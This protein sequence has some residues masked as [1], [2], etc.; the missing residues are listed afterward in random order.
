MKHNQL[1]IIGLL[2]TTIIFSC[3]NDSEEKTTITTSEVTPKKEVK[4]RVLTPEQSDKVN[5]LWSKVSVNVDT[6]SFIRFMTSA[7]IA[8]TLLS[9][10]S[11]FTV[12]APNNDSFEVFTD[13]SNL[14]NNPAQKEELKTLLKNHIVIGSMNSSQ[15]VQA[16]KKDGK[17]TFTTLTGD[18]LTATMDGNDIVLTN[19]AGTTAKVKKSDIMA[20]NGVLHVVDAVLK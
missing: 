8:D 12:F 9:P 3:K 6:K 20:S 16:I 15:L 10:S 19:K 13:K 4:K 14:T 1:L 5:S 17:V 18:S 2:A 7:G 11:K